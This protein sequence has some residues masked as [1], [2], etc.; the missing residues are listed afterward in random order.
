MKAYR[1]PDCQCR[2]IEKQIDEEF[3]NCDWNFDKAC[4]ARRERSADLKDNDIEFEP[5]SDKCYGCVCPT[6]GRMVCNG[7]A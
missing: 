6:C 7:C 4:K 3:P 2:E 1:D 5:H